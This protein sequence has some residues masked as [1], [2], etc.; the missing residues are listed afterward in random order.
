MKILL[1]NDDGITSPGITLLAAALRNAG[2]RVFIFAPT[3]NRSGTSHSITFIFEPVRIKETDSDTWSCS[4]TPADC[5]VLALLG[6]IPELDITTEDNNV[7]NLKNAPD[8]VLSGMNK[9]ANL[10]TDIIYSGTAAAARQGSIF[11]IP[12]VALSLVENNGE[13]HWDPAICFFIQKFDEILNSWKEGTF[14]NINFPNNETQPSALV[15]AFPSKR[16]Y[17]DRI[18]NYTAPNG[19][20]YC[21]PKLG[22]TR[23]KEEKG[24]DWDEI[25]KNN[26]S[27]SVIVSQPVSVLQGGFR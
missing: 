12:S 24:S 16:S 1:T 8:L 25:T 21:F 15:S 22:N 14:V 19:R 7:L 2:H 18:V 5:A 10:G 23:T 27:L 17:D 20:L 13:W 4:G 6:G 11:G 9:G 3:K 26:A